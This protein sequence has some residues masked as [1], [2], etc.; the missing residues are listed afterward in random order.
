M[1]PQRALRG[2][3]LRPGRIAASAVVLLVLAACGPADRPIEAS[4]LEALP[5]GATKVTPTDDIY[6]P[7]LHS[8]EWMEP[9]PM[10]G[11]INTAGAEDSPF[12]TPDGATMYFFFTPDA[13]AAPE[14]QLSD[15]VTGI[16]VSHLVAGSWD[17]PQRVVTA[18]E[19]VESLDGCPFVDDGIMW[20]C[21]AR[22]G[23]FRPIDIYLSHLVDGEWSVGETAG[24]TLNRD[25]DVGELHLAA[26]GQELYFHSPRPGGAGDFDIWVTRLVEGTWVE[27]VA[28]TA[29][30]TDGREGWPYLSPDGS[31]LWFTRIHEG[32]PAIFRSLLSAGEW[33]EPE[34]VVSRFAGEPTLD[35]AGN[36]YFVHHFVVDGR[37]IEADIY[38]ARR[39]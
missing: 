38:V 33:S 21:S 16:W 20:F 25:Y 7:V 30:N 29:V 37:I 28:V 13:A 1:T 5:P 36:L 32:A 19:G 35:A 14:D 10:A 23:G 26:S 22:A 11:P 27:P 15:G 18:A 6:P 3:H 12:V 4:R 34:L 2:R 9:E 31:E 8:T 17:E 39:R 24:A